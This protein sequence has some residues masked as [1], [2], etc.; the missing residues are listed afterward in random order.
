MAAGS[1]RAKAIV[2][3]LI[4]SKT[5]VHD[6]T[7]VVWDPG[8][9]RCQPATTT[10][11]LAQAGISQT[12]ELVTHQRGI[13]PFSGDALLLDGQLYSP[14]LSNELRDLKALRGLGP[15]TTSAPSRTG[16]TS[17]RGGASF[18]MLQP[19]R[20]DSRGG[21]V[22]FAPDCSEAASSRR[23]CEGHEP[24]LWSKFQTRQIDAA[25]ESCLHRRSS[26]R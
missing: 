19:T 21:S 12:I 20:T 6:I 4:E 18:A 24:V 22:P 1:H 8:Y 23:R 15:L 26:Y 2:E 10:Y 7:D 3:E 25:R 5:Q 14:F 13:R 9:S 17:V 11:P 16:S